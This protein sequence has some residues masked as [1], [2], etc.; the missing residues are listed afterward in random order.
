MRITAVAKEL[1]FSAEYLRSLERTGRIPPAPRDI[2]GHRRFSQ[3]EVAH[4][5]T[6]LFA[7]HE[8]V[9]RE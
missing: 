4:L 6:V 9:A 2:N 3:Q 5:R 1:G 7:D 8:S